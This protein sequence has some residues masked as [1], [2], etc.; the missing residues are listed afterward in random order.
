MPA[1]SSCSTDN[2]SD[3]AF[4][5]IPSGPSAVFLAAMLS[6]VVV[7]GVEWSLP[8]GFGSSVGISPI[9]CTLEHLRFHGFRGGGLLAL[10]CSAQF[11][12]ASPMGLGLLF[13]RDPPRLFS[14]PLS[15]CGLQG[16]HSCSI[17]L[18]GLFQLIVTARLFSSPMLKP[19]TCRDAFPSPLFQFG[20]PP[21]CGALSWVFNSRHRSVANLGHL[22]LKP[23]CPFLC[24]SR[25]RLLRRS[26]PC[27]C[28][29]RS[30]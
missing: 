25:C 30:E 21:I 5:G 26:D 23:L 1:I 3:N 24:L 14:L 11:C 4:P 13:L 12:R 8:G 19:A 16:Y 20:G 10:V 17:S 6:S 18:A 9:Q 27:R 7:T 2:A 28:L 15:N 29:R 22:G